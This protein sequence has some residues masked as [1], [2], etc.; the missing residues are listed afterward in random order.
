MNGSYADWFQA[1]FTALEPLLGK[2]DGRVWSAP[3]PLHLS[4]DSSVL[5]FRSYV[6]GVVY[7]ICDLIGLSDQ[8]PNSLGQYELMICTRQE[9]EWAPELIS[10]LARATMED[11]LEVGETMDIGPALPEG[12]TIVA[13]LFTTPD[14]PQERFTVR[15]VTAGILLCV[16]I[17]E[18]E[19]RL[20]RG[21]QTERVL[22]DLRR[23]G[24]FPFT[25][26]QRRSIS[27]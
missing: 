23:A 15:G 3:V 18:D 20:C 26:L 8:Q 5:V 19:L 11:V 16:G 1:H 24:V 14:L 12:S 25:D 4:G 9:E 27:L 21:G 6:D 2:A 7:V 10:R 17:T 13:L 22:A